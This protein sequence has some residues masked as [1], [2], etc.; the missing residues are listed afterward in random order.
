[1]QRASHP[2]WRAELPALD[3][4]EAA[5]ENRGSVPGPLLG[6]HCSLRFKY[7]AFM[8]IHLDPLAPKILNCSPCTGMNSSPGPLPASFWV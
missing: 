3:S 7:G 1:M 4:T 5:N 8:V 6:A 2:S